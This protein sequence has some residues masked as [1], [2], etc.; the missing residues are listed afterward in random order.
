MSPLTVEDEE[1]EEGVDTVGQH[2]GQ[3]ENDDDVDDGD[4]GDDGDD[5]CK[6][7]HNHPHPHSHQQQQQ[8]GHPQPHHPFHVLPPSTHVPFYDTLDEY[9]SDD[10]D[11]QDDAGPPPVNYLEVAQ[12]LTSDMDV[13]PSVGSSGEFE[14]DSPTP[15]IGQGS[16]QVGGA[17]LL[18]SSETQP[19]PP[20]PLG[21]MLSQ[22]PAPIHPPPLNPSAVSTQLE[23]L[24]AGAN[25]PVLSAL[26]TFSA[27]FEGT[28]PVALT[29]PNPGTLGPGN[30]GLSDFLHCWARQ[31]RSLS[32][33]PRERSRYPWPS[34]INDLTSKTLNHVQYADLAGDLCDL[35]GIDWE[36]LGVSRK[37]AR[38]RRLLTYNN[39]V[40]HHGSDRWTVSI[41]S[42]A[43]PFPSEA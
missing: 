41:A 4:D 28:H 27:W 5:D 40:N 21:L 25:N 26:S 14:F 29:N 20:P 38:E 6:Y 43:S 12:L 24:V 3:G 9:V 35:Q 13:D 31:S 39:Y 34:R 8:Y 17:N 18:L 10:L 16:Q 32:G 37:E 42:M 15:D 23:Q 2:G 33:L 36:E 7:Y 11:M 19:F 22:L 30:Y 1:A